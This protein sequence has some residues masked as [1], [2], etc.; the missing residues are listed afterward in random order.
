MS[1]IP[2]DARALLNF[3]G[4]KEAPKG[5]DQPYGGVTVQPPRP[6][7]SMTINEVL[8]WQDEAVRRGS[9]SSAAGRYQFIR[10]TLRST[11]RQM[12]LSGNERW[13]PDLQDQMAFHLLRGRGYDKFR[14]GEISAERFANNVAREWASM[15]VVSGPKAGRSY[16]DG[17]GLNKSLVNVNDYMGAVAGDWQGGITMS[18]RDREPPGFPVRPGV[19]QPRPL[20]QDNPFPRARKPLLSRLGGWI[21]GLLS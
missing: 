5:Y 20:T 19:V 4:N 21:K 6:L 2:A 10:G 16:Y 7:T 11:V 14:S 13:S 12:G 3:I 15:P 9:K 17:D 1:T 8:A 18:A